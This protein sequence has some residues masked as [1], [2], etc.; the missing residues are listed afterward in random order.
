MCSIEDNS[1]LSLP[2]EKE[3]VYIVLKKKNKRER[4]KKAARMSRILKI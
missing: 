2:C 3:K 1:E 4:Q